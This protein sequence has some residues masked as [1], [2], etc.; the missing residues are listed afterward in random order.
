MHAPAPPP[1]PRSPVVAAPPARCEA[2]VVVEKPRHSRADLDALPANVVG[3][4]VAGTLHVSPRPAAPHALAASVIGRDLGGSFH[5]GRGGGEPGGWWI[6][7]EPELAL[8]GDVLVPDLAGWR[9]ERMPTIADV[10]SFIVAPDWICEIVSP[11]TGRLDRVVKMPVYLRA[12]V[13]HLWIV[14]PIARTLEVYVAH[15]GRWVV[16]AAHGGAER[17]R[18][19]PFDAIELDLA[20][21]WDRGEPPDP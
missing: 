18:A 10:A 6:L 20:A 4:L 17:V 3:E 21:W 5:R 7:D 14:D 13:G 12:G 16:L 19:R 15:D 1:L 11:S 9:R 2:S 8:G